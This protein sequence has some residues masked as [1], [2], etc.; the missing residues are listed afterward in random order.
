VAV[1]VD[2]ATA[3]DPSAPGSFGWAG[4]ANTFFWV[5]PRNALI[6]MVWTQHFPFGAYPLQ[7]DVERIVYAALASQSHPAR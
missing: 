3:D 5:D 6:G 4:A 2:S 1:Q 7:P